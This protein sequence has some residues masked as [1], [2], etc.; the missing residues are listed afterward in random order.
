VARVPALWR[1]KA[2]H[3]RIECEPDDALRHPAR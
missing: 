1:T 2:H 3:R